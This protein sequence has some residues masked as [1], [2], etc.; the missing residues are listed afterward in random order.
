M[1]GAGVVTAPDFLDRFLAGDRLAL[2]RA[3]LAAPMAGT[4]TSLDVEPGE[5]VAP[6]SPIVVLSDVTGL[7]VD[8]N[9]DETDVVG[10][11][12]GQEARL[13]LDALPGVELPGEVSYV[14]S[15]AQNQSGV[16]LYPVTVRLAPDDPAAGP[17]AG[18]AE[19]PAMGLRQASGQA[20]SLRVGMTA[21][22]EI[23]AAESRG[24]VLV[25]VEA[26]RETSPGQYT[27]FVVTPDG[28]LEMRTV[29]VGLMDPVNAEVLDGLEPGDIVSIG[30]AE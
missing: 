22:V 1:R 8:I 4:I 10:V 23:V 14:A 17:A 7:E 27:V 25:P 12:A 3:T 16:V 13:G 11:T 2:A 26:L 6:G 18:S 29:V 28:E 5:M 19:G 20:A 15:V 30:E 9:L 21:E 24:A